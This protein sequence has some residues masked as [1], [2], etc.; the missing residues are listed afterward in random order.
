MKSGRLRHR[1]E[2]QHLSY[3]PPDPTSGHSKKEWL[4]L[5]THP[6]QAEVLEGAGR[7][8]FQAGTIQ[9][10]TTA[11]INL[12][13]FPV[14]RA[15]LVRMRVIWDGQVFEILEA[16]RDSTGRKEWRLRC[17]DGVTDG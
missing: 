5:F 8:A 15:D 7:E 10:E 4:P 1:I 2:I 14:D 17:K 13:W 6:I 3:G 9:A 12:R 16:V 11:R